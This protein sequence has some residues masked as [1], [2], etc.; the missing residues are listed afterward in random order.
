M[1]FFG[2]IQYFNPFSINEKYITS[3]APTQYKTLINDYP[4]PRIVGVKPNPSVYG[5]LVSLGIYFNL[6]YYKYAKKKWIVWLSIALCLI[7]L[8]MTLTRTIQ[9]AFLCS[10]ILFIL[11]NVW[12]KKGWKRA[13]QITMITVIAIILILIFL[14]RSLT[15]RLFEILDLSNANSWLE[16]INKWNEYTDIIKNNI[17]LG[18]GPVKN[19]MVQVGHVDSEW[20]QILLQYGALGFMLY[21]LMLISPIWD[22]LK[23]KNNKNILKYYIPLLFIV[24]INNISASSLLSFDTAIGIYI[25]IGLLFTEKE[26]KKH[27][28]KR[29]I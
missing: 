10:L 24:I 16:R 6:M 2:I 12:I 19:Y 17:L 1:V 22:Y 3:Y 14:P 28:E 15:W 11:I 21:V 9:V 29:N 26:E 5:I 13:L 18:V 27:E 20:I 25:F 4:T 8:M 23:N 7:N